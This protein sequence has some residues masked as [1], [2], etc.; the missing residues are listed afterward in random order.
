MINY[1]DLI[2]EPVSVCKI[3][4]EHLQD[5]R[6]VYCKRCAQIR[7]ESYNAARM[8]LLKHIKSNSHKLII[9]LLS[10]KQFSCELKKIIEE[11]AKNGKE[12]G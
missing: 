11:V 7:T 12:K 8:H 9:D 4:G 6:R 10:D 2:H 1:I 3:C 5:E